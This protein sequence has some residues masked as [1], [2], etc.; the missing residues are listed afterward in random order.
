M[1]KADYYELLG[2]ERGASADDLKKAY[3][4]L[5]M[6]YHPDRNPGDKAA[7]AK[8]KE[9]NE[10][11]DVL[12]D[13][14]KRAA[15]DRFGHQA[16]ENGGGGN[17]GGGGFGAGGF[18]SF[19]DIFEEMFGGGMGR[20]QA[21][22]P[23]RGSDLRYNLEVSMED[24]FKGNAATIRIPNWVACEGCKGSG[25]NNGAQPIT[26]TTCSGAGKIRAQQGFFTVERTCH[27][28]GGMGKIIKDPCR[29]CGGTGRT[30]K[31]KT[32]QVNIP[33]G[34]EDGTRIRL[35]GEGEM[36]LRG[37]ASGDLYVFITVKPHRFFQRDGADLK[38]RVPIAM[39][40]AALGGTIEVPTIDGKR[41]RVTVPHGTQSGQQMRLKGKGMSVMRSSQRGDLYIEMVVE[42]PVNLTK[43]QKEL[44]AEFDKSGGK[45][46]T[47]PQSESFFGKVKELWE[48]LTE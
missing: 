5:A 22:Q 16:F 46:S 19:S 17:P 36:G 38:C 28:C 10:A 24:A 42:T 9:L 23:G 35:T 12:K 37:A 29:I 18:G 47:S 6:Q 4:K 20:G 30:R 48:D 3:R 25:G 44:L 41:N 7:E 2:A 8:F 21:Q 26:C 1:A 27:T 14:Q 13:D 15:Y 11:Y 43:K 31:E 40:T 34:V 39:T 45:E 33:A 32:L